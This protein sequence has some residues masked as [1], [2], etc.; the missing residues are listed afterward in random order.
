MQKTPLHLP[1]LMM[2]TMLFSLLST[3]SCKHDPLVV[4]MDPG[5]TTDTA[6]PNDPVDNS[7]WPCSP[8]SV[9]F[10]YQILPILV[11]NCAMEGCHSAASHKEGVNLTSFS[12]VMSTGE[13]KAGKLSGDFWESINSN[14]PDKQMPPLPA[15]KL[16]AEQISMIRTWILQG[17][18]DLTC[19]SGYGGC[20]TEAMSF[21]S[22]I[23]PI[24]QSSC[25]GCH[26]GT[27]PQ[28]GFELVTYNGVVKM[29]QNGKLLGS[30][31]KE[32]G[33]IA[34]PPAGNGLTTCSII[35]LQA[36][37]D[38]GMLNN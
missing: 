15:G 18:K 5:D 19:N 12:K 10:A 1:F 36:W 14:D 20:S 13:V 24:L 28:G 34:M 21:S 27:N 33:Y 29:A 37:I 30:V 2:A 16:A 8:D 26:G 25:T 11:S 9:Y 22:D 35:H 17:A 4:A 38:Q 32:T 7:G 3:S 31:K 23:K 6:N